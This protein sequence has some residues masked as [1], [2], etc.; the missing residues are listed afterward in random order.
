MRMH[1]LAECLASGQLN[2]PIN[3][4][5]VHELSPQP[6]TKEQKEKAK[7]I[8]TYLYSMDVMGQPDV[9]FE[10]TGKSD[11]ILPWHKQILQI[12]G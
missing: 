5:R 7:L 9:A 4:N 11:Y 3:H 2:G 8:H 1:F 10:A 12:G 6:A